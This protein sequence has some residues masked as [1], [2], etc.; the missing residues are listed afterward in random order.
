MV[1]EALDAMFR[2]DWFDI[3]HLR[4]ILVVLDVPQDS[5]SYR[6]LRTLHCVHWRA[7]R[8]ETR[9]LFPQLIN[10]AL[11]PTRAEC[12]ATNAALRGITF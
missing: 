9:Q 1:Q 4:D 7:M 8:P 10:E 6:L 5:E 2:R 12:T 3:T 11:A